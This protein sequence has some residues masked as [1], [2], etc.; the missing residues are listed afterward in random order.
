MSD[1]FKEVD[2]LYM[3]SIWDFPVDGPKIRQESRFDLFESLILSL[4][5]PKKGFVFDK[6]FFCPVSEFCIGYVLKDRFDCEVPVIRGN[7]FH[8]CSFEYDRNE[9]FSKNSCVSNYD[10]FSRYIRVL[11]L[12]ENDRSYKTHFRTPHLKT[13]SLQPKLAI[14]LISSNGR[15]FIPV[16]SFEYGFVWAYPDSISY[17]LEYDDKRKMA[18]GSLISRGILDGRLPFYGS[19]ITCDEFFKNALYLTSCVYKIRKRNHMVNIFAL[20]DEMTETLKRGPY[21]FFL[22][23]L[24]AKFIGKG[25]FYECR[26]PHQVVSVCS[27]KPTKHSG[28]SYDRFV[29]ERYS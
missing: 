14:N 12:I 1:Q 28:D 23:Q 7:V 6:E 20:S 15:S 27:F 22:G 4:G 8:S 5:L 9:F 24:F 11:E 10:D 13:V 19:R 26:R 17:P 3:S 29:K 25:C 16:D 2:Y 18:I 21:F